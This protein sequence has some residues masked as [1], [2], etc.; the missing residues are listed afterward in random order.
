MVANK[1]CS[2]FLITLLTC[3]AFCYQGALIVAQAPAKTSGVAFISVEE[4]KTKLAANESLVIIDVRS[5]ETFAN[6]DKKIIGAIH[7]KVRRIEQRITLP[8]LKDVPRDRPVV[9][10]CS[11]PADESAISAAR[12]FLENGFKNVRALKGGWREWVKVS[13]PTETKPRL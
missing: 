12:V 5:S 1:R 8:P 10:Y 2:R 3:I 6:S 7:M 11:C 9:T 4:L 13:G